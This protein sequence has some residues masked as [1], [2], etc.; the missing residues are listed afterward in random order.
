MT[1]ERAAGQ[2]GD[3][4]EHLGRRFIWIE[5][6]LV[7]L[8]IPAILV[9]SHR[10]DE[11]GYLWVLLAPLTIVLVNV[12]LL[13]RKAYRADISLGFTALAAAV[14]HSSF[15]V[16]ATDL[17]AAIVLVMAGSIMA[18][19]SP[20]R[21]ISFTVAYSMFMAALVLYWGRDD[22]SGPLNAFTAVAVFT[23]GSFFLINIK[24]SAASSGARLGQY[25]AAMNQLPIPIF[26][27]DFSGLLAEFD[28][29]RHGGVSDIRSHVAETPGE[30][31]RLMSLITVLDAN[32]SAES[33]FGAD[34][35][36]LLGSLQPIEADG[37]NFEPY[38]TELEAIWNGEDQIGSSVLIQ[39]DPDV[40]GAVKWVVPLHETTKTT[41]VAITDIS[42]LVEQRNALSELN[43][44]KD[45]FVAAISHELR[46]PLTA[47]LGFATEL[48][49]GPAEMSQ[50]EKS[51]LLQVI[52]EQS[53]EMAHIVEDLLV[54]ARADLGALAVS[55]TPCDLPTL[56]RETLNE[57]GQRIRVDHAG[58][59]TGYVDP[60]RFRQIVRNL[61]TNAERYG[62]KNRWI[63][64]IQDPDFASVMVSDDGP[65]V[66]PEMA[67]KIFDSFVTAH[68]PKA[69]TA[70]MG[71][72]LSVSR[73]LS[74]LM[75]GNLVY[76]AAADGSK[77]ILTVPSKR[78]A[79][80]PTA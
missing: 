29:L 32:Q 75:G 78:P 35:T 39:T 50:R 60:V 68:A 16:H 38:L 28:R 18:V 15:G 31:T 40:T 48:A 77:F 66:P 71:L 37:R 44:S 22:G 62:G 6:I 43:R 58:D 25:R 11:P 49:N 69:V 24:E 12:A 45:E 8:A 21:R 23:L 3:S 73:H 42:E 1:K 27:D 7:A 46:T 79:D 54:S 9:E 63:E 72:G 2:G 13:A 30:L 65:G 10:V 5:T 47:V 74:H 76:R 19:Y 53:Q 52:V 64:I 33:F 34:R 26:E 80:S 36:T 4:I 51:D 59:V 41:F 70:S 56:V 55:A 20:G 57:L 14:A 17:P 67:E 61:V